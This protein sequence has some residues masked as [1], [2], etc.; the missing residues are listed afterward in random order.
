[1]PNWRVYF[2]RRNEAPQIWSIDEGDQTSETNVKDWKLH[3]CD[4]DSHEDLSVKPNPD[5][6]TAWVEVI[7]ATMQ[8]IHG[9]AHFF[10]DENWRVPKLAPAKLTPAQEE[11]ENQ[12]RINELP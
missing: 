8:I 5:T 7:H 4:A 2:N 10:H 9:V 11:E 1:M 3:R 6:P 12:R